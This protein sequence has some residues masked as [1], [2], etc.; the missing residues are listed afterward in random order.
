MSDIDFRFY[1]LTASTVEQTLPLLLQKTLERGKR[2][3]LRFPSM[4]RLEAVN[5]LLWTYE[6]RAFLPHGG[7]KQGRGTDQPIWLTCDA[8][9]PNQADYLFLL[10]GCPPDAFEEFEMVALMFD[11]RDEEAVATARG[12]WKELRDIEDLKLSYWRQSP[13]GAWEKAA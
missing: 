4:E 9:N 6:D 12:Y 13:Q 10:D 1:H 11:A 2:A 7:P 5:Q 8:D 3:Q